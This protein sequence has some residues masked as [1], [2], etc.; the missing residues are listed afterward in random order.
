MKRRKVNKKD[1]IDGNAGMLFGNNLCL[2][3]KKHL[4]IGIKFL[5]K[6]NEIRINSDKSFDRKIYMKFIKFIYTVC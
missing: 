2:L 3:Q 5:D 4:H 6:F 1:L